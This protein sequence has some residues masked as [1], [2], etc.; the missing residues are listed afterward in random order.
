MGIFKNTQN[1]EN[2][3][4]N[5]LYLSLGFSNYQYMSDLVSSIFL[6]ILTSSHPA[7]LF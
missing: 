6:T 4:V 5:P 1:K 3:I 7:G 2:R